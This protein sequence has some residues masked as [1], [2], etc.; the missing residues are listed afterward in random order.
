MSDTTVNPQPERD[1]EWAE[2]QDDGE[3]P[4]DHATPSQAA[5]Q[6]ARL[7]PEEVKIRF[8]E[9]APQHMRKLI[10]TGIPKAEVIVNFIKDATEN[11][12]I[13]LSSGQA[14]AHYDAAWRQRKREAIEGYFIAKGNLKRRKRTREGEET[15]QQLANF[16][17]KSMRRVVRDDGA[18]R[19]TLL[20]IEAQFGGRTF[21]TEISIEEFQGMKWPIKV[22]GTGA[23]TAPRNAQEVYYG[24]QRHAQHETDKLIY[25]H[26]GWRTVDGKPHYLH[27]GG[28]IGAEGARYDI[29][30]TLPTSKM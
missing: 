28:A 10:D 23:R 20:E 7:T 14:E 26:T 27:A 11:G 6:P 17:L 15:V 29:K 18:E 19:Q 2:E 30:A 4:S 9:L 22:M 21:K 16:Y 8:S 12:G 3:P 13:E 1:L 24:L 25:T 5:T